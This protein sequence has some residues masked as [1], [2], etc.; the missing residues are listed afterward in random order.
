MSEAKVRG[1]N[2]KYRPEAIKRMDE[3]A[4]LKGGVNKVYEEAVD[5]YISIHEEQSKPIKHSGWID[6][7]KI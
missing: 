2:I 7:W 3:I 6:K 4:A 5:I 1:P